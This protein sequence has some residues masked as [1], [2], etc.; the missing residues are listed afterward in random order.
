[1][2]ISKNNWL[3]SKYIIFLLS[4]LAIGLTLFVYALVNMNNF[5]GL[6]QYNESVLYWMSTHRSP[7]VNTIMEV[8]TSTASPIMFVVIVTFGSALWAFLKH[9]VWRPF[10]ASATIVV[11][12]ISS[13]LIKILVQQ[14][15]PAEFDMVPPFE[16]GFSFPS[17]HT[18]STIV[19]LLVVGYLFYS[20]YHNQDKHF[21]LA[22]WMIGAISGTLIIAISRLYLGYHWLSDIIGAIGFGLI[23]F[24][25]TIYIDKLYA[26]RKKTRVSI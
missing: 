16:T 7:A 19:F 18:L 25:A 8:L 26:H 1:M 13:S 11:S 17:G 2:K 12:A 24:A 15:R 10:I 5:S 14:S 6:G 20:R 21:W 22:I 3:S 4:I 9:E 23:I